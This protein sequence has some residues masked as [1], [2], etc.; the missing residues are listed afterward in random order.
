[1]SV[2][3]EEKGL[4]EKR[5]VEFSDGRLS[6]SEDEGQELTWTEEE[7]KALVRR[8][9]F[10]IMPLLILGFFALQIDR[11]N[12]GNALTD[13][14]LRDVGITQFQFNV[15]QQLLSAGIVLLEIPSNII[16]Y[17]LGPTVWIGGQI[18]A[19]GLVATLQAFQKGLGSYLATRLLLG[20]CEA[21][22]IPA[23]LFTMTRWYKRDE[24]TSR[25]SIY[26]LGNLLSAACSGL[27]AYGI[28]HMRGIGGLAGWQWLFLLE[29][30]FTVLVGI[31]F[32]CLFPISAAN[33]VS[34]IGLRYFNERESQ[35][36]QQRVLR[37]D[38]SKVQARQNI[39]LEEVKTTF[40]NWRLI[41]H[42][43]MTIVAL[44][45]A[46]TMG[47]YA[48]TLVISMGYERLQ[49]NA[50]ASIGA[51]IQ[52]VMNVLWGVIAEKTRR[53]G[54]MVFLG[55]LIL[56]GTSLGNRLLV[57]S[58]NYPLK[59]GVLTAS[60]SFQ[61]PFHAVNGSWLSLNC[62][63]AGERSITM[64]MLIMCANIAGIVGSQ[65]FQ[66]QDA[67]LYR[68]GFTVI[69][70]FLSAAVVLATLANLQY[71]LLNKFQKRVGKDRYQY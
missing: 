60:L 21:G 51:W 27:I 42:L 11:G 56:W 36:L 16:L 24:S 3:Q 49:S 63:T 1:M 4:D 32:I 18:L 23:G 48:P 45:P 59:F 31:L 30:I 2:N 41:P 9:D 64:A 61:V 57:D 7:E 66:A 35:I 8:L 17:R 34:L 69:V 22:F 20:L 25:F 19:W 39:S 71:W 6:R 10:L 68:T 67:P 14:F 62:K 50:M 29:G 43:L 44:A 37:D 70:A 15:G 5:G 26:F 46:S 65:L 54:L 55:I 38:P 53:R 52:L 12:I 47:S 58:T 40:T 28:L 33:P 13:F